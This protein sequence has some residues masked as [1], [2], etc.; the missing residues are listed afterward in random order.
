MSQLEAQKGTVHFKRVETFVTIGPKKN[1][2]TPLLLFLLLQ[3]SSLFQSVSRCSIWPENQPICW[4]VACRA[5]QFFLFFFF[6]AC[7]VAGLSGSLCPEMEIWGKRGGPMI[8]GCDMA[9]G[10][11]IFTVCNENFCSKI[12]QSKKLFFFFFLRG[13]AEFLSVCALHGF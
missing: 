5:C 11:R 8:L 1:S 13:G 2:S 6:F 12:K 7:S 4:I 9:L 3:L 10:I